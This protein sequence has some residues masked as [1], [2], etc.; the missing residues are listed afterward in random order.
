MCSSERAK[1]RL[2]DE[3]ERKHYDD[4]TTKLCGSDFGQQRDYKIRIALEKGAN[5]IDNGP[6]IQ[7]RPGRRLPMQV[8]KRTLA[9]LCGFQKRSTMKL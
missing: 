6:G 3:A 9:V 4:E 1:A 5:V 8:R 2:L 7:L